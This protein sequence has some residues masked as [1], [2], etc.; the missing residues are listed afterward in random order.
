MNQEAY[1]N[2]AEIEERVDIEVIAYEEPSRDPSKTGNKP[3]QLVAVE[4]YGY[5][6]GRGKNKRVIFPDD[7]YKLAELGCNDT[8]IATWFSMD[9]NTL[10]YNFSDVIAKGRESLKHSLRRA[11]LHNAIKLN[12]AAVQIFLSKNLLGMSDNPSVTA[13][14]KP[15]PWTEEDA[16]S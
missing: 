13:D 10:L 16:A 4:V 8:E 14:T 6:C 7:V 2:D 15:L 3:K 12:N 5:E 9:R 11:M 1:S